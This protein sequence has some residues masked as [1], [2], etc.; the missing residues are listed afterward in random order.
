[1]ILLGIYLPIYVGSRYNILIRVEH[2]SLKFFTNFYFSTFFDRLLGL[3]HLFLLIGLIVSFRKKIINELNFVTIL[4]IFIFL[5]YFTPL[6]YGL[7]YKP[8][9]H[10]RYII[11]VLIPI[12]VVLSYLIFEIKINILKYYI[13]YFIFV[14]FEINLLNQI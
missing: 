5:S 9:I 10:S 3:V 13:I 4:I 14:S 6:L 11:F 12:I 2:P 1:M 7:L 8:I